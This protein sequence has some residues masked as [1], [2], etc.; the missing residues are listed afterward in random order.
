MEQIKVLLL[1]LPSFSERK[2]SR[3][4]MGGFG[5]EVGGSLM[6][7]P[8]PLAYTAAI[9]ERESIPVDLLD[10]EALD[11]S[12]EKILAHVKEGGFNLVGVISSL[13]TLRIDLAFIDRMKALCKGVKAFLTGPI[14]YLYR[15]FILEN[16]SCDF[17]INSLN[18]DKPVELVRALQQ[19]DVASLK[20]ISYRENGSV[21][22][23]L[24][25]DRMIEM[26][27]LPLPARRF[28]PNEK[29]FIAGMKGPMTT[30]QT[31]RGCP[32]R[33]TICT[34]KFSQGHIYRTRDLDH[35]ME[36][37][38]DIVHNLG[39]KNIVFRDITFTVNRKRIMELCDRLIDAKF[40]LTWWAETTL[41]LVD[42]E[43]ITKMAQAGMDAL[44]LGV[45]SGGEEQQKE[46]WAQKTFS[47]EKTREIFDCCHGLGVKT[48]GYFMMGFPGETE[49]SY[50]ETI[51]WAR[52][53]RPT[54]LQFLPYR[55][56]PCEIDE[57]TVVDPAVLRRIKKAYLAYYLT[58]SNLARQFLQPKLFLNRIKRFFSLREK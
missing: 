18:D 40:G 29:Y 32:Y 11:L 9:M 15:D 48:R 1:N 57:Y 49:Q 26:A 53:L 43:L 55:E 33:C 37:I 34:Y 38:E 25:E 27:S 6:Y 36:E 56:L 58:P 47:L 10:A 4:I 39:V 46:H 16:S 23:N 12:E 42:R 31:A 7:P 22:H 44:S 19:G 54:T 20:G 51:R 30:V 50:K 13:I 21:R 35:V 41:N 45:E 28:L 52:A 14:I 3:E 17:T 8:L 24:D 2:Y 5:L